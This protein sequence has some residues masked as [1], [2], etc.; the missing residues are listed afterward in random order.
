MSTTTT[1]KKTSN[2]TCDE[3]KKNITSRQCLHCSVC[4]RDYHPQCV[5]INEKIYYLMT[6][7]RK[8]NWSCPQCKVKPLDENC[9]TST[10]TVPSLASSNPGRKDDK[11]TRQAKQNQ[12]AKV[13]VGNE[14]D[15]NSSDLISIDDEQ[16]D[17]ILSS[18]STGEQLLEDTCNRSCPDL[19]LNYH[20]KLEELESKVS[21][22]QH[23]LMS[24]ESEIE[25]LLSENFTM[26]KIIT[27]NKNTIETLK[28]LCKSDSNHSQSKASKSHKKKTLGRQTLDLNGIDQHNSSF[29]ELNTQAA[30]SESEELQNQE[31]LPNS[32]NTDEEIVKSTEYKN[33]KTDKERED[34][35]HRKTI[36]SQTAQ[37]IQRKKRKLCIISNDSKNKILNAATRNFDNT[38]ICH[39]LTPGVGINVLFKEIDKKLESFTLDDYCIIFIGEQD[40]IMSENYSLKVEY[41]RT[42]IQKVQH[43]N[44]IICLPTYKC[45]TNV[46]LFN[47]RIETFNQLIY[48]DNLKYQYAYILDSNKD[49]ECSSY[50]FDYRNGS[51]NR[52]AFAKIF[53]NL[54]ELINSLT[55]LSTAQIQSNQLFLV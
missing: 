22:L 1:I 27:S 18:N 34:A 41:I 17:L 7:E 19:K 35:N 52:R 36:N 5:N 29:Y 33:K 55:K 48:L 12:P 21:I 6:R 4:R 38:Q 23:E 14:L 10:P 49:L 20:D 42:S 51:I 50:M 45:C 30:D 15:K 54:V 24:A 28:K 43:T 25:K 3:C 8:K 26:K 53:N 40:F 2:K 32:L 11:V 47:C 13:P 16:E 39:Y 46:D 31:T 37:T 44:V 9:K